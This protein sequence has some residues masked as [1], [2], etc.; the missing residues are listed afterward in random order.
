MTATPELFMPPETPVSRT[1]HTPVA[2]TVHSKNTARDRVFFP[3]KE[4]RVRGDALGLRRAL[5]VEH[6]R[7]L[8]GLVDIRTGRRAVG[9]GVG[10]RGWQRGGMRLAL[11]AYDGISSSN[12]YC[13]S[14]LGWWWYRAGDSNKTR[15]SIFLLASFSELLGQRGARATHQDFLAQF[16]AQLWQVRPELYAAVMDTEMQRCLLN[17][18]MRQCRALLLS[19]DQLLEVEQLTREAA[20]GQRTLLEA[21]PQL[22]RQNGERNG[23]SEPEQGGTDAQA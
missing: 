8:Q 13:I 16:L 18:R 4:L 12:I 15:G 10:A 22:F 17:Q 7:Y 6:D 3:L 23:E 5:A 14:E 1:V 19:L 2:A 21:F 9:Q 20:H 11:G